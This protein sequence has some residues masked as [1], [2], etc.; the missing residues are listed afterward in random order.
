M[1][2][3]QLSVVELRVDSLEMI[4]LSL[5]PCL[6]EK[7][8]LEKQLDVTWMT[9]CVEPRNVLD[10]G[11]VGGNASRFHSDWPTLSFTGIAVSVYDGE[12]LYFNA[13]VMTQ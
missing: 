10:R 1:F 7:Q 4:S 2:Y 8:N 9:K 12:I 6:N 13:P 3:P 5:F 11:A